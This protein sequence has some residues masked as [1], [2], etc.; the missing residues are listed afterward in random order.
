MGKGPKKPNMTVTSRFFHE[1][2]R[3]ASR[4]IANPF[5]NPPPGRAPIARL[6]SRGP[7]PK[8][9]WT[10]SDLADWISASLP[11]AIFFLD[12]GIFTR[13]L[14][15]KIWDALK[16]KRIPIIPGVAQELL[17]WLRN[18]FCNGAIRDSVLAALKQ[19][20]PSTLAGRFPPSG[21]GLFAP[22]QA[23]ADH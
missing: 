5:P 2:S 16:K 13:E 7:T 4:Q 3:Q 11:V 12:T 20:S 15:P 23:F 8:L 19:G 21:F 18:P 22:G 17:P 14:D 9:S 1:R 6:H 10:N